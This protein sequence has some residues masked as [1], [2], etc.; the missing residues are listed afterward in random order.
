MYKVIQ[1]KG[2]P[3]C[4]LSVVLVLFFFKIS[5]T[6]ETARLKVQTQRIR[7]ISILP[8][9]DTLSLNTKNVLDN[10]HSESIRCK[11]NTIKFTTSE[12]VLIEESPFSSFELKSNKMFGAQL[13]GQANRMLSSRIYSTTDDLE[14]RQEKLFS[15]LSMAGVGIARDF[16]SYGVRRPIIE[17]KKG[18]YNFRAS[19]FLTGLSHK[20][21]IDLIYRL[22][23][24][25]N[26]RESGKPEDMAAYLNYVKTVVER[27]DGDDDFGC[28]L[29]YPDCYKK[30]DA[31]YPVVSKA[32]G[33]EWGRRHRVYYWEVLKEPEPG[34]RNRMGNE[35]GLEPDD[36]R[37]I[38]KKTSEVIHAADDRAKVIFAGMGPV[39]KHGGYTEDFYY[40]Q[41]LKKGGVETFHIAGVDAFTKTVT[42]KLER[43]NKV[44]NRYKRP[45]PLWVTQTG[46][47]N[48]PHRPHQ[49]NLFNGGGNPD[50][51]C[52]Y[53]AKTFTDA[54]AA[55]AKKV[56]WGDFLDNSKAENRPSTI[57]DATGL[58]E[59]ETWK[60]RPAYF[61]YKLMA[62]ALKNFKSVERISSHAYKF[63]F[64]NR[65]TIYVILPETG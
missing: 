18:Q 10:F 16:M 51:Q 64:S 57:W 39:G 9:G 30:G 56:F 34:R 14:K 6:R 19:D 32:D 59:T 38:L 53:V 65:S 47:P 26:P 41:M 3:I 61:T 27:Y 48:R 45:K 44:L 5:D 22:S 28:V 1:R 33:R 35:A 50:A 40:E 37:E 63:N 20:Y 62:T 54:F 15:I 29:S 49:K 8:D 24:H 36:S 12:P 4:A 42:E 23:L 46:V 21:N 52:I 11:D 25:I 60:L 17:R 58:F 43:Y 55:G 31:Q 7:K 13:A 2:W